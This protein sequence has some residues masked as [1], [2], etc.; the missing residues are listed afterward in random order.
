M[1]GTGDFWLSRVFIILQNKKDRIF[2]FFFLQFLLL[3]LKLDLDSVFRV[4]VHFMIVSFFLYLFGR[5]GAY[6]CFNVEYSFGQ[7][8]PTITT[9]TVTKFSLNGSSLRSG[10]WP[11]ASSFLYL[12]FP[13][14]T[15]LSIFRRI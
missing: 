6:I 1:E 2:F 5:R 15:M 13:L 9:K 8:V 10:S 12:Y 11:V 4:F 14:P 3:L 7:F